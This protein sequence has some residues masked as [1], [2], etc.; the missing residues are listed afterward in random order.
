MN[1]PSALEAE[2]PPYRLVLKIFWVAIWLGDVCSNQI[3]ARHIIACRKTVL[4]ALW[5]H[6]SWN[7]TKKRKTLKA[8][9]AT[10]GVCSHSCV[11]L[12]LGCVSCCEVT[13]SVIGPRGFYLAVLTGHVSDFLFFFFP[14]FPSLSSPH[15]LIGHLELI[16][17]TFI[18]AF[19]L[20]WKREKEKKK[21]RS[22][23]S[24]FFFVRL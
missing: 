12:F 7:L 21:R 8:P 24:F 1:I 15:G 6:S 18:K 16:T 9:K 4:L 11:A 13:G 14:L 3:W 10:G 23:F 5:P 20:S 17:D 19:Q 2:K 22:T